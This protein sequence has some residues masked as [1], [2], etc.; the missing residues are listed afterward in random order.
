MQNALLNQKKG[1][2]VLARLLTLDLSTKS[3]GYCVIDMNNP[4]A[5]LDY[6]CIKSSAQD[7]EKRIII[8]R[9]R[10]QELIRQYNI[11]KIVAEEVVNVPNTNTYKKLTWLQGVIV[12]SVYEI[13]K[14]I[15]IDFVNSSAWRSEIGIKTG[16]GVKRTTLKQADIDYVKTTY[17]ISANDDICDAI[18]LKDAYISRAKN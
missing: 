1:L 10:I 4:S 2:A 6:G 11:T 13:N 12:V 16:R 3:T 17:N 14:D 8:M 9:D 18:C 15:E 5:L 7:I